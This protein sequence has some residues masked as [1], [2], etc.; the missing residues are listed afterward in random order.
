MGRTPTAMQ[1]LDAIGIDSICE[2]IADGKSL[3]AIARE[4]DVGIGSLSTWLA[5]DSDRSARAREARA[6]TARL[7]DERAEEEIRAAT[8]PLELGI[9]RELAHHY[10]WRAAKIAPKEYGERQHVEHSGQIELASALEA[11]RARVKSTEPL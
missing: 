3:T 9:A 11:A 6:D 10:R 4:A 8:D 1:K 7:W 2:K 5:A